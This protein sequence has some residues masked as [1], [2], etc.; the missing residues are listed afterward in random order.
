MTDGN[1][2]VYAIAA[3]ASYADG[4]TIPEGKKIGDENVSARTLVQMGTKAE[5]NAAS[6]SAV[7]NWLGSDGNEI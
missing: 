3:G 7:M 1:P 6:A 2:V 5:I 4:D